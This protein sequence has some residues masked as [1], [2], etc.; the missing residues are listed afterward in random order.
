MEHRFTYIQGCQLYRLRSYIVVLPPKQSAICIRILTVNVIQQGCMQQNRQR[1]E[2][3]LNWPYCV[4]KRPVFM[5]LFL[6][7]D[8][9]WAWYT[10]SIY[11]QLPTT[12]IAHTS[13]WTFRHIFKFCVKHWFFHI[14][15]HTITTSP[16]VTTA[17]VF[18]GRYAKYYP[19]CTT[20][21]WQRRTNVSSSTYRP[22]RP[23]RKTQLRQMMQP[24]RIRLLMCDCDSRMNL[25]HVQEKN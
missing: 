17:S 19:D 15:P 16:P 18:I 6:R 8:V 5:K 13:V 21:T 12:Q 23:C 7:W 20:R 1:S 11:C 10:S 22:S 3:E 24:I 9:Y 14:L 2:G 25:E 4:S